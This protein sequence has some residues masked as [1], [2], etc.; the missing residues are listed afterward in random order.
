M[1][2]IKVEKSSQKAGADYLTR[3]NRQEEEYE[4]EIRS[5]GQKYFIDC[6]RQRGETRVLSNQQQDLT[7]KKLK[8][9]QKDE[10]KQKGLE[11]LVIEN[12]L[13]MEKKVKLCLGLLKMQEQLLEREQA[14]LN[15]QQT[16]QGAEDSKRALENYRSIL[17]Q[18]L[19]SLKRTKDEAV[20]ETRVRQ[21]TLKKM[22]QE[23]VSE[24]EENRECDGQNRRLESRKVFL[25]SE[26]DGLGQMME[27]LGR[28]KDLVSRRMLKLLP[29]KADNEGF[30]LPPLPK[31][32]FPIFLN[33]FII[34]PN[35]K[36]LTYIKKIKSRNL[37][38]ITT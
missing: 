2:L 5:L 20:H 1:Y 37:K 28:K 8:M 35:L 36:I 34:I 26:L 33:T 10:L 17:K 11:A 21:N 14:V 9:D 18:K 19:G 22:F 3:I 32:T 30:N 29:G 31:V 23:L 4:R 16:I 12:T 27:E 24:I 6:E 13:L 15:K 7:D 38:I 25:E